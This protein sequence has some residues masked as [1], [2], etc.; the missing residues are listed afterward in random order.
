MN[1]QEHST[2]LG[3]GASHAQADEAFVDAA[4]ALYH[5]A[6]ALDPDITSFWISRRVRPGEADDGMPNMV[7]F[8]RR[9][10]GE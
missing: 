9:E 8:N 10:I 1:S 6:K 4:I 5:A 3:G 2:A 7:G